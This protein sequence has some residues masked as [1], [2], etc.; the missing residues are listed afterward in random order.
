MIGPALLDAVLARS[1]GKHSR[2]HGPEHWVR[3]AASGAALVKG[4]PAADPLVVLLF[5]LFHDSMRE[6]DGCDPLHGFR[7]ASLAREILE[8]GRVLPAERLSALAYACEWHD[9]GG[10]SEDP[11][12]GACWDAD[13]LNLWRVSITPH[14]GLLS[15]AAARDPTMIGRCKTLQDEPA[16]SWAALDEWYGRMGGF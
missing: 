5:A 1:T 4:T 7:G 6:N 11:T 3:V 16:P 9:A 8:D 12:I 14:P 2:I 10:V 15:T 13:R